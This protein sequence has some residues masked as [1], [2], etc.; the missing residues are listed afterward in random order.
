[1]KAVILTLL[2]CFILSLTACEKITV[3]PEPEEPQEEQKQSE[4]NGQ[5][6]GNANTQTMTMEI[7]ADGKTMINDGTAEIQLYDQFFKSETIIP[8]E[9]EGKTFAVKGFI[10]NFKGTLEMYPIEIKDNAAPSIPEDVD[11]NGDVNVGDVN[12]VLGII[13]NEGYD[14]AADVNGDGAVN[15]GDVNQILAYI[16]AHA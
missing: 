15:V 7:T 5:Q 12:I 1:M 6:N 4:D 9:V 2:S 14:S 10:V 16:L 3:P 11:G 8:T 13:I